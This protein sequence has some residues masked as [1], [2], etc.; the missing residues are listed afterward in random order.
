M[1]QSTALE[2]RARDK[3]PLLGALEAVWLDRALF[4][5]CIFSTAL[6][7]VLFPFILPQLLDDLE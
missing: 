6:H 4:V 2:H 3:A 5:S 1:G 7:N